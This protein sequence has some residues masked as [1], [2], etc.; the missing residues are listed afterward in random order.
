M[1]KIV[2]PMLATSGQ[3]DISKFNYPICVQPKLD[4]Y[5]CFGHPTMGYVTRNLKPFPNKFVTQMLDMLYR[6]RFGANEH[7]WKFDG[8]LMVTE[9]FSDQ[10]QLR[11]I[12]GMPK[13]TFHVFDIVDPCSPFH[14][15]RDILRSCKKELP[16][17]VK[18]VPTIEAYNEHDL[19]SIH[20][21]NLIG[22]YEG[23]IIR[24][25]KGEYKYGRATEKS[26]VLMKMK[27]L[28]DEEAKIV[29]FVPKFKNV[30]EAK[31]NALG[32]TE[33]AKRKETLVA[34]ETLGALQVRRL[35]D[36]QIFQL[37]SGLND[38]TRKWI[39]D[40]RAQV[41]GEIV[42]YTN[43]IDSKTDARDLPRFPIF[44]CFRHAWDMSE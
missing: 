43:Q 5:R 17:W 3:V 35:R 9:N 33:R 15:R 11:R 26:Q 1:S 36:G 20:E 28:E 38:W 44:K 10:G 31:T 2:K 34:Q 27:E 29:G 39:W 23:S 22:G 18:I 8:E 4:G 25:L 30:A 32:R 19:L 7:E 42:T 13:F 21:D 40:N 6:I 16:E 24:S 41:V 37:G 14:V 12:E